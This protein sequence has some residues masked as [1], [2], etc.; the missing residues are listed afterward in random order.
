MINKLFTLSEAMRTALEQKSA[1][2]LV[3]EEFKTLEDAARNVQDQDD[4]EEED[5]DDDGLNIDVPMVDEV[6]SKYED[7]QTNLEEARKAAKS[8][9]DHANDATIYSLLEAAKDAWIRATNPP[10]RGRGSGSRGRGRGISGFTASGGNAAPLSL[11]PAAPIVAY[12]RLN[13]IAF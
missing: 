3:E 7:A 11:S 4:D 12:A 2:C 5:D 6:A 13:L 9:Q 10:K 1:L 8:A